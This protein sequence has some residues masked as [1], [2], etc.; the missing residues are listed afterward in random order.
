M[1]EIGREDSGEEDTRSGRCGL[2]SPGQSLVQ[3]LRWTGGDMLLLPGKGG[4]EGW[5]QMSVCL[6]LCVCRLF[7]LD[8]MYFFLKIF[9]SFLF[10]I[11]FHGIIYI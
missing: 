8:S 10:L 2:L 11:N 7:L 6:C 1:G 3:G 5:G 4:H 9:F